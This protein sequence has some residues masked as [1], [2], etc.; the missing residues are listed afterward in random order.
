MFSIHLPK[1]STV[2]REHIYLGAGLLLI[3]A[4]LAAIATVAG[5]AVKKAQMRDA[6][7]ASQRDAVIYCVETLRGAARNNCVHQAKEDPYGADT[8]PLVGNSAAFTHSSAVAS[9]G[10]PGLM[11]VGFSV[12]R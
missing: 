8:T 5:G 1:I 3:V 12:H 9:N 7:L 6:L 10:I 11:P 2:S 4:M